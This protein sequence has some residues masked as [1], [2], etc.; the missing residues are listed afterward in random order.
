[1]NFITENWL[2]LLV[3]IMAFAKVITNLTPTE[4]DNK[5]FGWLDT[6]I[7]SLVPKYTKKK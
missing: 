5:I 6:I 2:E 4:K 7:D 1:M 3:G